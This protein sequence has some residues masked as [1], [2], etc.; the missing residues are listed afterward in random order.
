M[1]LHG[2][3]LGSPWRLGSPWLPGAPLLRAPAGWS[4]LG[5]AGKDLKQ[6]AAHVP[7][8]RIPG[9]GIDGLVPSA[10]DRV[11]G[12][13]ARLPCAAG[14]GR[15]APG[16]PGLAWTVD[17]GP[18]MPVP[19]GF[20]RVHRAWTRWTRRG[21]C[22]RHRHL[23][24]S[25]G[26]NDREPSRGGRLASTCSRIIGYSRWCAAPSTEA[27]P[28]WRTSS[29]RLHRSFVLSA[30]EAG[31]EEGTRAQ[32]GGGE[33]G[34]RRFKSQI[35]GEAGTTSPSHRWR[36]GPLPLP[37]C[38][39][40]R[41]SDRKPNGGAWR[42]CA[43][44]SG[45]RTSSCRLHRSFVLSAREAGDSFPCRQGV[46]FPCRLTPLPRCA[47][48]RR[49]DRRPNGGAWRCC[50]ARSGGAQAALA[51][52]GIRWRGR[53]EGGV[54]AVWQEWR[55]TPAGLRR[56]PATARARCGRRPELPT[57]SLLLTSIRDA[58][59]K[60]FLRDGGAA[61]ELAAISAAALCG[62]PLE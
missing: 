30:R 41:R 47:A 40:E 8:H 60:G 46:S 43:A 14:I 52:P 24:R 54:R 4:G 36:D 33:V 2:L 13:E 1:T 59:E 5:P 55:A 62:A 53:G 7:R 34:L 44:R 50:A 29:C 20:S 25:R 12:A 42:C 58:A 6:G 10:S 27:R 38:A 9:A 19:S 51:G 39:A 45:W 11:S 16:H 17:S 21:P 37:R 26:A 15:S 61:V 23:P 57:F 18:P 48:E 31:G 28:G 22:R 32:R 3:C 56:K 35:V 49:F